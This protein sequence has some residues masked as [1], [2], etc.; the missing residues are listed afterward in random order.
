MKFFRIAAVIVIALS[1]AISAYAGPLDNPTGDL[2]PPVKI[3]LVY[4]NQVQTGYAIMCNSEP[5]ILIDSLRN[6]FDFADMANSGTGAYMV[7]NTAVDKYYYNGNLYLDLADFCAAVNVRPKYD[8]QKSQIIFTSG[9][10]ADEIKAPQSPVIKVKLYNLTKGDNQDP[11]NNKSFMYSVGLTNK[12]NSMVT[13]NHFN[14]VLI[15][16]SGKKYVSVK[17]WTYDVVYGNNDTP[18]NL[19]LEPGQEHKV[20][21]TFNLPD[22]DTPSKF[23]IYQNQK[24]IGYSDAGGN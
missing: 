13:L 11:N 20:S 18:D 21:L 19:Y 5:F 15:G 2:Q 16:Q 23:V 1:M 3:D 6:L 24:V 14:F 17:N 8:A 9:K 22:D 10:Q 12:T 4:N 7:N